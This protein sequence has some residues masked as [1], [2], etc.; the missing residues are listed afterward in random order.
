MEALATVLEFG[1]DRSR[2]GQA[3]MCLLPKRSVRCVWLSHLICLK[4]F[5][6]FASMCE[7]L[8]FEV[9]KS[10]HANQEA[11]ASKSR[12]HIAWAVPQPMETLKPRWLGLSKINEALNPAPDEQLRMHNG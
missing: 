7:D 1:R 11:L 10:M 5:A 3:G 4:E 8:S 12:P 9:R 2:L 6:L